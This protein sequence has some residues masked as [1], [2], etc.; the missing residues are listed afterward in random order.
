MPGFMRYSCDSR[1]LLL[2]PR[3]N[4]SAGGSEYVA[5][6]LDYPEAAI[7]PSH[8]CPTAR[9][10]LIAVN[11]E[12]PENNVTRGT[13]IADRCATNYLCYSS[14]STISQVIVIC[15]ISC[16]AESDSSGTQ[17]RR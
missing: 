4:P 13:L 14:S 6:Y 9:F 12:K 11:R 5:L 1:R 8:L 7:T 16:L 3:G 15:W 2:F 10:E 17:F